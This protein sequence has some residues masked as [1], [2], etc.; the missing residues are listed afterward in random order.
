MG[1][2]K[3][4]KYGSRLML[5]GDLSTSYLYQVQVYPYPVF[6]L[7]CHMF[8]LLY[9][10]AIFHYTLYGEWDTCIRESLRNE[11]FMFIGAAAICDTAIQHAKRKNQEVA[12]FSFSS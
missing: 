9:V 12:N 1:V 3:S 5:A 2:R 10:I 4:E 6:I 8:I 11:I 7:L